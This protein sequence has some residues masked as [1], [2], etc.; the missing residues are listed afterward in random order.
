MTITRFKTHYSKS[1]CFLVIPLF[2]LHTT[3][4]HAS[5]KFHD[6]LQEIIF[7][8]LDYFQWTHHFFNTIFQTNWCQARMYYFSELTQRSW[9]IWGLVRSMIL[10]W[11]YGMAAFTTRKTISQWT[12]HTTSLVRKIPCEHKQK[13]ASGAFKIF[14]CMLKILAIIELCQLN[15]L[16]LPC[17]NCFGEGLVAPLTP[18]QNSLST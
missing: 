6:F 4:G 16:L 7:S 17:S 11:I 8:C 13:I 10:M 9:Y 3:S 2:N 12:L 5:H 14:F 18:T 1:R 15:V